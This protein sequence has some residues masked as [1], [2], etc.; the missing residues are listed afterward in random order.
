MYKGQYAI[1]PNQS[2]IKLNK[3]QTLNIRG[4]YYIQMYLIRN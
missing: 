3:F 2:D 4:V 1:K